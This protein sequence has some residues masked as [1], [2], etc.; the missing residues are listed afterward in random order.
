MQAICRRAKLVEI[1]RS[2]ADELAAEIREIAAKIAQAKATV[3]KLR[4]VQEKI[5]RL[6]PAML[7]AVGTDSGEKCPPSRANVSLRV[8]RLSQAIREVE[9]AMSMVADDDASELRQL[10]KKL[11]RMAEHAPSLFNIPGMR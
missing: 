3:E 6:L 11:R 1:A 9:D 10:V 4:R 7:A 8:S 5:D 2:T